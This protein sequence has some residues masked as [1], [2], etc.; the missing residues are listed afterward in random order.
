[1]RSK[2]PAEIVPDY[3]VPKDWN[4]HFTI[5]DR[6]DI[7]I[8][9]SEFRAPDQVVDMTRE[10]YLIALNLAIAGYGG[11][12]VVMLSSYWAKLLVA[13]TYWKNGGHPFPVVNFCSLW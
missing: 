5:N 7:D 3:T 6:P 4:I 12:L 11:A 8:W 10:G 13:Y 2:L 9:N 1:M